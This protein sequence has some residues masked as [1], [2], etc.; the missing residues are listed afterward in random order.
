MQTA[1]PGR[2]VGARYCEGIKKNYLN[3]NKERQ[4]VVVS[5]PFIVQ[6]DWYGVSSF[7]NTLS[8]SGI[9]VLVVQD[10]QWAVVS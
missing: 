10:D 8:V 6:D 2:R 3:M 7:Q 1:R 9:Y 5:H 4:H